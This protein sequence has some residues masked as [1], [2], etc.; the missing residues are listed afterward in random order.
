MLTFEDYMRGIVSRVARIISILRLEKHIFVDTP[1]LLRCNFAFVFAILDY[2]SPM[3][4]SAAECHLQLLER[5][6]YSVARLCLDLSFF[7][8]CHR[9]RMAGLRMLYKINS[10]YNHCVFTKRPSVCFY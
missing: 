9:R 4:G 8:L 2:C 5:Q 1:V 10:N 3:W 6:V 7:S